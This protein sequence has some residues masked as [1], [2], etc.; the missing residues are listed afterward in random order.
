MKYNRLEKLAYERGYRVSDEGI[1]SST[2]KKNIGCMRNGYHFLTMKVDGKNKNI[3]SHRLLAYQKYGDKIYEPGTVVRHL[4]G[5]SSNNH[6][7][8]I[9]IGTHSDNMMDMPKEVRLA[10]AKHATSFIK[11][12]DHAEVLDFYHK[13]R[14]YKQTM[15]KFGISSK[16]TLYF[17]IKQSTD[18]RNKINNTVTTLA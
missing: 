5:D 2:N 18:G 12:H 17:I 1:V 4:D 14:S 10:K 13:T 11:K 3:R 16:G 9:C 15:D 8:N 7:S 6:V